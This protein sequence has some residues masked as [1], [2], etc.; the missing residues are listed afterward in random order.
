MVLKGE[1]IR[2]CDA[3]NVHSDFTRPSGIFNWS[4]D[5][6]H[7]REI[8][9]EEEFA[10]VYASKDERTHP[11]DRDGAVAAFERHLAKTADKTVCDVELSTVKKNGE[12]RYFREICESKHDANGNP[13]RNASASMDITESRQLTDALNAAVLESQKTIGIMST[14]LNSTDAMIYVSDRKTSELLF[15]NEYM[16]QHFGIEGDIRG[17]PCYQVLHGF[18]GGQCEWCPR[19]KLDLNPGEPYT[20][21]MRNP[22]TNRFYRCTDRYVHWPGGI[23]AHVQ[24]CVDLTDI[25]QMQDEL[26]D[27]Q[28]MLHTINSAAFH[29]LNSDIDTFEGI[30]QQSML[31]L[32][33]TLDIDRI[34]IWKNFISEGELFTSLVF[35]CAESAPSVHKD[36]LAVN[37]AY[38]AELPDWFD[39]L[40][41]G[42]SIN[43]LVR[44]IPRKVQSKLK[45]L[46]VKALLVLPIFVED[47]FWG[48][49]GFDNRH[50]EKMFTERE[51]SVL[52]SASALFVHAWIRNEILA[53]LRD[54]S[55]QLELALSEAQLANRS[56]DHFLR[57][58]SHEIRTPMN[59]ILG[60]T[61]LQLQSDELDRTGKQTFQR[62]HASG[63]MLLGIINDILDMSKMD[64]GRLTVTPETYEIASLINDTL[65]TN[66][67]H[68]GSDPIEFHL[69][70]AENTPALL[71]GDAL[72]IKQILN[73]LL[74]NAFKYTSAGHVSLSCYT[75]PGSDE[76]NI[77]LVFEVSDTGQGLTQDQLSQIFDMYTRFNLESN[78]TIAGTGL[79]MSILKN[80]LDMMNGEIQMESEPGKGSKFTVK[81]PQGRVGPE[82]LDAELIQNLQ[83]FELYGGSQLKRV[84]IAREPMP[85]GKVLIV[86]D[87]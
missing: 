38:R 17:Q 67:I 45:W 54:T 47:Q 86:D 26:N 14:I 28:R 29:L 55:S 78:Q 68:A 82:V 11:E 43:S 63:V 23:R 53:S 41:S 57:T 7:V 36:K 25:R 50:S 44:D 46:G 62:I 2:L 15:I 76:D 75:E 87:V 65:Q 39:I 5:F 32:A 10:S 72:R 21:E 70:I 35:D 13:A 73:N 83:R 37:V 9:D 4:D 64:A 61:E 74:S 8:T 12:H 49:V 81:I 27:S 6:R 18:T 24:H 60:L 58:V 52:L 85:Y 30:L 34:T 3:D 84:L 16:K 71:W 51:E 42:E 79:G 80:L 40:S 69:H 48:F 31:S 59:V 77:S 20:W 66:L 33:K 1:K 19:T 22:R 56:K